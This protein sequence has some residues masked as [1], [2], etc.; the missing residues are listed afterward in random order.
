MTEQ[1]QDTGPQYEFT[2]DWFSQNVPVWRQIIS[3][4]K[5]TKIL[6]IGSFEG[7]SNC[8]IIEMCTE[9]SQ[10]DIEVYCVDTWEGGIEHQKGGQIETQMSEVEQRF[11]RNI[12]V[13]RSKSKKAASVFK[14]K[15]YSNRN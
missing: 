2:R 11:D 6:E 15:K 13:A 12:S 8:W 1:A 4:D 14:I 10:S 3:K 9:H 5:P 7:R